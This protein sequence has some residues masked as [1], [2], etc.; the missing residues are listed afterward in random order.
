M[1]KLKRKTEWTAEE[2]KALRA[3]LVAWRLSRT[4]LAKTTAIEMQSVALNLGSMLWG[5]DN[6]NRMYSLRD[7]SQQ[8]VQTNAAI[9]HLDNCDT[10]LELENRATGKT[11]AYFDVTGY[12]TGMEEKP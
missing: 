10:L 7:V 11:T 4:E 12:D 2:L 6:T 1:K 9:S 3:K 5:G 8:I